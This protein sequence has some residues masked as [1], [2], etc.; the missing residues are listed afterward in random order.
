MDDPEGDRYGLG[1][2]VTPE[3]LFH[4][5]TAPEL[6]AEGSDPR[7]G[8]SKDDDGISNSQSISCGRGEG[9]LIEGT[10]E[11]VVNPAS[12]RSSER[13]KLRAVLNE[14]GR[15]KRSM[16]QDVKSSVKAIK[17]E[18]TGSKTGTEERERKDD[19]KG[20]N[21]DLKG[22]NREKGT[23]V[24]SRFE[25]DSDNKEN[26]FKGKLQGRHHS[27]RMSS[28]HGRPY[29]SCDVRSSGRGRT[30]GSRSD[31]YGGNEFSDRFCANG[32]HGN[33][34]GFGSYDNQGSFNGPNFR[35]CSGNF[36]DHD[37]HS[38]NDSFSNNDWH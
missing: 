34:N 3:G 5:D 18:G 8:F 22:D 15:V 26:V 7:V 25:R 14:R 35:G 29:D 4:T 2:N 13:P 32:P 31:R 12:D 9:E 38:Y 20:K 27:D 10:G 28:K 17:S 6:S 37:F 21:S 36:N 30:G 19:S 16:K 33:A 1:T 24:A 23:R 11:R